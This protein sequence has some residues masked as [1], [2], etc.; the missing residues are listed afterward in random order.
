MYY[1]DFILERNRHAFYITAK[2]LSKNIDRL[3]N[4]AS[5][6]KW[7]IISARIIVCCVRYLG[8]TCSVCAALWEVLCII[9]YVHTILIFA[10]QQ[11]KGKVMEWRKKRWRG[12]AVRGIKKSK[13]NEKEVKEKQEEIELKEMQRQS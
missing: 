6:S 5:Y 7:F 4:L 11:N 12:K 8:L 10:W 13:K 2:D 1:L 9:Q 3:K